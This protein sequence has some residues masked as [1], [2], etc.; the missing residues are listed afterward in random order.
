MLRLLLLFVKNA[1]VRVVAH[2]AQ[3]RAFRLVH[4][5]LPKTVRHCYC[6][7]ETKH[8]RNRP[9]NPRHCFWHHWIG[10]CCYNSHGGA[11][12]VRTT[13]WDATFETSTTTKLLLMMSTS[14]R[15]I[16]EEWWI[17]AS[18]ER[19]CGCEATQ[20]NTTGSARF[21]FGRAILCC[22]ALRCVVLCCVLVL[23]LSIQ[24]TVNTSISKLYCSYCFNYFRPPAKFTS[25][26]NRFT[27][28]P[29]RTVRTV[30]VIYST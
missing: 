18:L 28:L 8:N 15:M 14:F 13:L 17:L 2:R 22:V 10:Y 30:Y 6:Y 3:F 12:V 21:F 16:R 11:I 25:R 1:P 19:C 26:N 24:L 27:V 5:N 4:K 23:L 7:F 29:E 20:H 9:H